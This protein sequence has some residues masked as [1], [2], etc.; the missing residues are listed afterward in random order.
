M[1]TAPRASLLVTVSPSSNTIPMQR[2][3]TRPNLFQWMTIRVKKVSG[4]NKLFIRDAEPAGFPA[5][6]CCLSFRFE[7]ITDP[8]IGEDV[9]R[10]LIGFNFL[11]QL[12]DEHAQI[13]GLLHTLAAP[14]GIEQDAMR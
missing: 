3:W 11:A 6:G 10:S 7:A 5:S 2:V 12:V 4:R 8:G 9:L 13:L 1:Q 14:D